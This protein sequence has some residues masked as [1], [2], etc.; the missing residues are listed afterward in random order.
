MGDEALP[1]LPP[2]D[3]ARLPRHVAIIMDGN[4][5]WAQAR[6]LP[7]AAG[8]RAGTENLRRI[9][10]AAAEFGIA[11]LTI[12]AFS[13]ENWTRPRAEVEALMRI[14]AGALRDELDELDRGG[15][16]IRHIG[17]R[18]G[19]PGAL[20]RAID[21]AV[22][23]TA[24]NTRLTLNVAFNYG[25]RAEIVDAVKKIIAEGLPA[26]AVDEAVLA[27]HLTTGGQ[28]DPDLLIRTGGDM[29]VSNF[30]IWQVAYAEFYSTPIYWPDFGREQLHEALT[31][32]AGRQR[33]FG[34]LPGAAG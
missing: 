10:R 2:L 18:E 28:P 19:V 13:T 32:F 1:P 9:I 23:R 26:E 8:H 20:M 12:Y 4:G 5:R 29:R 3:P 15:V 7:R 16:R 11:T 25:G 33:R 30:M 21:A 22:A 17:R 6:G 24:P 34:G 27:A 14:L 31:V